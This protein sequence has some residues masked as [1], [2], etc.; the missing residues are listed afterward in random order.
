MHVTAKVLLLGASIIALSACTAVRNQR[1]YVPETPIMES[2]V[3]GEDT[4]LSVSQKL[5]NPTLDATFDEN[6]WY[7][8]SSSDVQAA[9]F[10]S[11]SLEREIYE[12][13][14]SPEG[15]V[16]SVNFYDLE[17]ARDVQSP[18]DVESLF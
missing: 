11:Q 16:A 2:I 10:P 1:G 18:D 4:K 7:Y 13:H 14:F 5:G 6:T 3:I 15:Q 17:D 8:V 12:V 9:F